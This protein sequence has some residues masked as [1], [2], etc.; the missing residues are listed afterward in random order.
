MEHSTGALWGL[1]AAVSLSE[2]QNR[3]CERAWV[4]LCFQ[5][6]CSLLFPH[7]RQH[8]GALEPL[9]GFLRGCRRQRESLQ[10]AVLVSDSSWA[11]PESTGPTALLFH[12]GVLLPTGVEPCS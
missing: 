1:L 2:G 11:A 6:G 12:K 3:G 7:S 5:P 9:P 10:G 4:S 8:L